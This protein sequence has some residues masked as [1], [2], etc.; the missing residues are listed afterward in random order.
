MTCGIE[1]MSRQ[2][3]SHS[4]DLCALIIM[5][6]Q[7]HKQATVACFAEQQIRL[8]FAGKAT[9]PSA[10]C[11]NPKPRHLRR[12]RL[13]PGKFQNREYD[14]IANPKLPRARGTPGRGTD[15]EPARGISLRDSLTQHRNRVLASLYKPYSPEGDVREFCLSC[16]PAGISS[17]GHTAQIKNLEI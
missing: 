10:T 7:I 3:T 1:T 16:K 14:R 15:A 8:L 11:W 2:R 4:N 9:N 17:M 5:N 12:P 13:L 6:R